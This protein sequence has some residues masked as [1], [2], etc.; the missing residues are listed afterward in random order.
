MGQAD[1]ETELLSLYEGVQGEIVD[2]IVGFRSIWGSRDEGKIL[3]E[4]EFCL[5]TPQSK[6]LS[7]WA[8]V[9]RMRSEGVCGRTPNEKVEECLKGVRFHHNKANYLLEA[10]KRFEEGDESIIEVL[11]RFGSAKEARDWFVKNIKGLGLKEAS[12]FL[13]NIGY[14]EDLAILDRHILRNLVRADVLSEVPRTLTRERYI[15]IESKMD[16]YSKKVRIPLSHLDLLLWYRQTGC[17][18]K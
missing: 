3:S 17:V 1:F 14:T 2:R 11:E 15:S 9:E 7:C 13:R 18:F 16:A 8:A 6:A 4:L 5:L 10:M 12:H